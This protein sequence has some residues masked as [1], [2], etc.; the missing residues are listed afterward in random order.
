MSYQQRKLTRR[1]SVSQ[2]S[3]VRP[4]LRQFDLLPERPKTTAKERGLPKE[5]I[6]K[7]RQISG[8]IKFLTGLFLA[9]LSL[10][11]LTRWRNASTKERHRAILAVSEDHIWELRGN[12]PPPGLMTPAVGQRKFLVNDWQLFSSWND[13]R[14]DIEV[15]LSIA[16]LVNRELVLP[17]FV[18]ASACQY[19]I[20][21]CVKIAPMLVQDESIDIRSVSHPERYP[22]PDDGLHSLRPQLPSRNSRGWVV[23]LQL[24]LDIQHLSAKSK[25]V[26]QFNDYLK[27]V[28]AHDP[29]T[30]RPS[31]GMANGQWSTDYNHQMSYHQIS[32]KFLD[33]ATG[34]KVD[35]LTTTYKPLFIKNHISG[36]YTSLMP[37]ATSKVVA[38]CNTTLNTIERLRSNLFNNSVNSRGIGRSQDIEARIWNDNPITSELRFDVSMKKRESSLFE[39]CLST[40]GYQSVYGFDEVSWHTQAPLGPARYIKSFETLGGVWD[41]LNFRLEQIL[42]IKDFSVIHSP[43]GGML[44]STPQAR[45]EFTHLTRIA[46]QFPEA[47]SELTSRLEKRMRVKCGGRAWRAAFLD[48]NDFIANKSDSSLMLSQR[49]EQQLVKMIGE[50][51]ENSITRLKKGHKLLKPLDRAFR[52]GKKPPQRNDPIYVSANKT[53][54]KKLE[55]FLNGVNIVTLEDLLEDKDRELLSVFLFK[56]ALELVDQSLLVRAGYFVGQTSFISGWVSNKRKAIGVDDDLSQLVNDIENPKS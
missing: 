3:V 40:G 20:S 44:W 49:N 38:K 27:L 1:S 33:F 22:D 32:G 13:L 2:G 29:D 53:A 12:K 46:F 17:A 39:S 41:D 4:G 26:I 37:E 31:L 16:T 10:Y 5:S 15:L 11:T 8:T 18:Y 45:E 21:E 24:V 36:S 52:T 7:T 47:Y 19:E 48:E 34:P 23:P 30:F 9:T 51:L 25:H 42:H 14:R 35:R 6:H 55:S 43:P 54:T 56:D 50:A 28:T